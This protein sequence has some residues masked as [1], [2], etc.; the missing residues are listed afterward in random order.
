MFFFTNPDRIFRATPMTTQ[1]TRIN[2]TSPSWPSTCVSI[3]AN[4][5]ISSRIESNST[6]VPTIRP[7]SPSIDKRWPHSTP[8]ISLS[9]ATRTSSDSDFALMT[10]MHSSST[11]KA[12]Q[13]YRKILHFLFKKNIRRGIQNAE[14]VFFFP[15]FYHEKHF[16]GIAE[17]FLSLS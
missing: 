12:C 14:I 17:N 10:R 16:C 15:K 3:R 1:Y 7:R 13:K 5:T 2:C 8:V 4:G 9:T 11:Q 6:A